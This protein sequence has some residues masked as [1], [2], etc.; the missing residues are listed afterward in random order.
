M[1]L[2]SEIER[3]FWRRYDWRIKCAHNRRFGRLKI[4]LFLSVQTI[5]D[6]LIWFA[7]EFEEMS[8]LSGYVLFL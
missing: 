1:R 7:S 3:H 8:F 6:G 5:V 2:L 4:L